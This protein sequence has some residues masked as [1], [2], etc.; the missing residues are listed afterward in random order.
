MATF[1]KRWSSG[2]R[3][4]LLLPLVGYKFFWIAVLGA[5][6]YNLNKPDS[7]DSM[8]YPTQVNWINWDTYMLLGGIAAVCI[9]SL[10]ARTIASRHNSSKLGHLAHGFSTVTLIIAL[11]GGGIFGIGNFMS[12]LNNYYAQTGLVKA[13]NVYIPILI[14]AGLLIFV[15][16]KAFVGS[17][18]EDDE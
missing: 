6:L 9:T 11:V 15:I 13:A 7:Y 17:K 12:T 8:G 10:I 16:L 4:A 3:L 5:S 1:I 2:E 18:G 14:D